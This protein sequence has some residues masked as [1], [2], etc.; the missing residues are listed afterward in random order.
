MSALQN[1]KF[2]FETN[3]IQLNIQETEVGKDVT[4]SCFSARI[5]D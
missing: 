2:Y 3:K 5:L 4:S 1:L